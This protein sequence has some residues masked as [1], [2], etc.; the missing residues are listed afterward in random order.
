MKSL[1]ALFLSIVLTFG[2]FTPVATPASAAENDPLGINASAAIAV[3]ASTGKVIYGKNVDESLGI[4][5]MTK[6]MTEYLLLEAIADG[7][8]SWD[9]TYQPSEYVYQISQYRSLSNVPLRKDG[10]Y[11]VRELYEAMA[12]YSANGAAIAIA[13]IVAGTETNFVKMMNDKA[14]ELGM[15]TA[16]FVNSTGLNNRDLLGM[17]PKGTGAEEENMMSARD[18]A[19]LAYHLINNYPEILETASIEKKVFQEGTED[20]IN[21]QNWNWMLPGLVYGYEGVDG[22]KTGYTDFAGSSFTA[23]AERNGMRI[24]SVVMNAQGS[25]SNQ[26]VHRFNETKKILNYA[27]SNFSVEELFPAEYQLPGETS[28]PVVKGKEKEVS[29][30]TNGSVKMAIK[31]GENDLY[32]PAFEY[33]E[34]LLNEEGALTAPIEKGTS[35]GSLIVKYNGE[36]QDL[37]Y[38]NG[39]NGGKIDVVTAEEVEKANWFVLTMRGIGG[40]FGDIWDGITNAV[41]GLFS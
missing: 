31:R 23:T 34:D 18:V 40:F 29:I 3:E 2:L 36:G 8:V 19:T 32:E 16:T 5:S 13:E 12:I 1:T 37:G 33:N 9:Q 17:H 14:K 30:H 39:I 22:L 25:G 7:K 4:A 26:Y 24:I 28:L 10:S 21:M 20:A 6:M 27:F 41:K 38:V 11:N 35:V 15:D